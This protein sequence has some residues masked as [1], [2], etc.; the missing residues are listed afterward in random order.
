MIFFQSEFFKLQKQKQYNVHS[1]IKNVW[2]SKNNN[3]NKEHKGHRISPT[4]F[5]ESHSFFMRY[6]FPSVCLCPDVF[7]FVNKQKIRFM[8]LIYVPFCFLGLHV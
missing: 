8:S 5:K 4:A 2:R 1:Q 6:N 3:N 7:L